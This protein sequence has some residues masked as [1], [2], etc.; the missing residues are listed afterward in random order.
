MLMDL[1]GKYL[2]VWLSPEGIET[3]LGVPV[4]AEERAMTTWTVAGQVIGERR[5]DCLLGEARA[6][7][8]RASLGA[9]DGSPAQWTLRAS[10]L[11]GAGAGTGTIPL[12]NAPSVL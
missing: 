6:A 10:T 8:H 1:P 5:P 9:A 7:A 3:F 4:P 2:V 11:Q 12:H